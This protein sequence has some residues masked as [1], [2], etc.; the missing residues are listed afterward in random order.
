MDISFACVALSS[1]PVSLGSC[2][3]I[4]FRHAV[5]FSLPAGGTNLFSV[6]GDLVAPLREFQDMS[7]VEK[8]NDLLQTLRDRIA[9]T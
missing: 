5:Q 2:V 9:S 6:S 4:Q 1:C 3:P 7:D 8:R